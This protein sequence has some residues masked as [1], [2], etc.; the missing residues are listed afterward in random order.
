MVNVHS[1]MS[2]L[3]NS[4]GK[5]SRVVYAKKLCNFTIVII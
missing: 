5:R 3:D 2:T 1:K 4:I